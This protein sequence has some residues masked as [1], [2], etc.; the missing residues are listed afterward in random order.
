VTVVRSIR[1]LPEQWDRWRGVAVARGFTLNRW[2]VRTLDTEA[3]RVE[4]EVRRVESEKS[5]REA[6]IRAKGGDY[7]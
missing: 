2:A 1:A 5:Q 6:L 4:A 3:D 7:S